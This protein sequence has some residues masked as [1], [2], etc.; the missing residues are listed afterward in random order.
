[1]FCLSMISQLPHGWKI[2]NIL[3]VGWI[4][5]SRGLQ[6]KALDEISSVTASAF[7]YNRSLVSTLIENSDCKKC[8]QYLKGLVVLLSSNEL[9][10]Q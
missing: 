5:Q 3:P 1:M 10:I 4:V 9:T 8:L 6:D 2:L 7:I